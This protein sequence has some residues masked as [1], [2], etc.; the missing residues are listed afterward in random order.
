M[1]LVP[2]EYEVQRLGL[3]DEADAV[4][5]AMLLDLAA[6]GLS[7]REIAWWT[8][9]ACWFPH[10][11]DHAAVR[12]LADALPADLRAGTPCEPQLLWSLP[13]EFDGEPWPHVDQPPPWAEGRRYLR[14]VGVALT[15]WTAANGAPLMH[16]AD[17]VRAAEMEAGDVL[18]MAPE[19][20]HTRG[21]NRSGQ[22]RA[23]AYFRFLEP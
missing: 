9:A 10:L 8:S 17:G 6:T 23:A 15:P 11:R 21:V 18:V 16:A 4:M 2:A 3:R 13:E 5:R 20:P 22:L 14:I 7:S 1:R 19:L 12:A